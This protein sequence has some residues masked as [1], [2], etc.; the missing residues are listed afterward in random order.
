MAVKPKIFKSVPFEKISTVCAPEFSSIVNLKVLNK[1]LYT[2]ICYP[3]MR[4]E[5][6]SIVDSK[7]VEKVLMKIDC[8]F[9][10]LVFIAHNFTDEAKKAL[11][12]INAVYFYRH[13]TYWSDESWEKIRDL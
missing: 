8:K 12:L 2:V 13:H 7:S 11:D 9:E 10:S 1:D 4:G 5:S 3:G 6:S